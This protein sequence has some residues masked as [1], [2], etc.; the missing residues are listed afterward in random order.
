VTL[1]NLLLNKSA[2]QTQGFQV[3]NVRLLRMLYI[4]EMKRSYVQ[5]LL[6]R[7]KIEPDCENDT[8]QTALWFTC[9]CPEKK[10]GC[11]QI[12][13]MLL[14][15]NIHLDLNSMLGYMPL[16]GTADRGEY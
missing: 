13:C 1:Y 10:H 2:L 4:K 11:W 12:F 14:E 5:V 3:S 16:M 15:H 7:E 6:S 8:G 9:N